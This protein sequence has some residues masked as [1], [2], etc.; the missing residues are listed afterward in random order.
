MYPTSIK[1]KRVKTFDEI[2]FTTFFRVITFGF[3]QANIYFIQSCCEVVFSSIDTASVE[4]IVQNL[5]FME[6]H[7]FQENKI[8]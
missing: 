4:V 1:I 5:R 3:L 7:Y 8:L 2:M 6:P